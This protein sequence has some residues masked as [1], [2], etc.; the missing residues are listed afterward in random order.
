MASDRQPICCPRWRALA[1][2]LYA[3]A[4]FPAA[5]SDVEAKVEAA[6]LFHLTRFVDWPALPANEVRICVLGAEAVGGMMADLSGRQV[7]DRPLKIEV[8]TVADPAA[9]QILFIGRGDKRLQELLH[10]LR[11]TAVLTVSDMDDFAR[12]G[13]MVGF[14]FEAGKIKLEINADT[15]RAANLKISAKLLEVARTVATP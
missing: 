6:Y 8:D 5:A 4:A 1:L 2:A 13:G 9:C 10:R 14:Y 3:A 12:R 11:G 7:R 15:A